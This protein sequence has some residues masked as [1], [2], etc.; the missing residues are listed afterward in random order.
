MEE[1]D[2]RIRMF[3]HEEIRERTRTGAG[4]VSIAAIRYK[5]RV[6]GVA[7]VFVSKLISTVG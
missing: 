7:F 1:E 3:S 6:Q 2:I 4:E 5:F